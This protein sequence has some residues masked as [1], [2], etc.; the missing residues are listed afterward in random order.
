LTSLEGFRATP[1]TIVTYNYDRSVEYAL[2]RALQVRWPGLAPADY[3]HALDCIGPIHLHGQLG[4]LPGFPGENGSEVP[5]GGDP[6]RLTD[7]NHIVA[8]SGIQIV[9]ESNPQAEPFI[10]ARDAIS[11]AERVIFLGFGYAATNVTRLALQTY[12]RRTADVYLCVKGFTPQQQVANVRCHF[13]PGIPHLEVG[14]E[15]EDIVQFF[16]RFPEAIL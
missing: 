13:G 6:D 4:R 16:R 2:A 14:T 10:R 1:L 5:F 11:A 7:A 15:D 3:A 12:I 9:H 8:A